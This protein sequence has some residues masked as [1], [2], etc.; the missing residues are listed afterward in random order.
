MPQ[1]WIID[2][3]LYD[4]SNIVGDLASYPK[5]IK[6]SALDNPWA[7]GGRNRVNQLNPE[8]YSTPT[9]RKMGEQNRPM[10]F[11][12]DPVIGPYFYQFERG[13]TVFIDPMFTDL[14]TGK[15]VNITKT[16]TYEFGSGNFLGDKMRKSNQVA[17]EWAAQQG[18]EVIPTLGRSGG[19]LTT[20][21][22]KFPTSDPA[23]IWNVQTSV[24]GNPNGYVLVSL[25]TLKSVFKDVFKLYDT[26]STKIDLGNSRFFVNLSS[27]N[28]VVPDDVL[29]Q[30]YA[31]NPNDNWGASIRL[32]S[33][34]GWLKPL[35][36]GVTIPLSMV[37]RQ[38][39]KTY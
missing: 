6:I 28:S 12:Y 22:V 10:Q 36:G 23:Y 8:L 15:K 27:I 38:N 11:Q 14:V 25:A 2:T 37:Q 9:S 35:Q 19:E 34:S 24:Y 30:A 18:K 17:D 31:A 16:F 7:P 39:K 20:Y 33:N 32:I 29:D 5:T 4:G 21:D 13:P 1:E 3:D 26:D